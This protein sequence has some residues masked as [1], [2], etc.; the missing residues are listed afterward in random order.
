MRPE[1]LADAI[2]A[3]F[4]HARGEFPELKLCCPLCGDTRFRLGVNVVRKT[5]HCFNC[6]S[7]LNAAGLCEALGLSASVWYEPTDFASLSEVLEGFN[8]STRQEKIE[9]SEDSLPRLDAMTFAEARGSRLWKVAVAYLESRG[10][11]AEYVAGTYGLLL[12]SP[13]SR[14]K[15]RLILPVYE[16]G[17]L[18]YY[19]ARALLK[20]QYPKYLNPPKAP[21]SKGKSH[22]VFNLDEAKIHGEVI[23]C[24][25]I[26]SAI[27]AGPNAVAIFGKELSDIQAMKI[28]S[29]GFKTVI[30]MLDAGER[31]AAVKAASK[32]CSRAETYIANLPYGDPNEV[33]PGELQET[34]A[35]L[36][37]FS[38]FDLILKSS[39]K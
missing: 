8:T 14:E 16:K 24:E 6:A 4:P 31:E 5:G 35:K 34:F 21:D 18:V 29:A 22:Y 36:E 10:Y 30:I 23:I 12:P 11:D 19:Q 2:R 3:K 25:G 7:R 33:L 39:R 27:S 9:L 1:Q 20:G 38:D 13:T 26:F 28:I 32:L 37:S 15:N 17:V